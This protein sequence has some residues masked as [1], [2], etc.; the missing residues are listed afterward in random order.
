MPDSTFS[1]FLKYS[2]GTFGNAKT[3]YLYKAEEGRR[4]K[5][6]L[7]KILIFPAWPARIFKLVSLVKAT[8]YFTIGG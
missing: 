4:S 6:A 5:Y 3:K 8:S 2:L 7:R 1:W